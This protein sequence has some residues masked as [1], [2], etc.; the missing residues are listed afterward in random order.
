MFGRFDTRL[1]THLYTLACLDDAVRFDHDANRSLQYLVTWI[2]GRSVACKL[3]WMCLL[4]WMLLASMVLLAQLLA[5]SLRSLLAWV[6]GCLVTSIFRALRSAFLE[7]I[8]RV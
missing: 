8:Q 7:S 6:I 5:R 1:G 3:A 2:M 4:A